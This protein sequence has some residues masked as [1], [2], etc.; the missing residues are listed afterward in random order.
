MNSSWYILRAIYVINMISISNGK[1]FRVI[2]TILHF[3][4]WLA[5]TGSR[6]KKTFL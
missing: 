5:V 1:D 6:I 2:R 4:D 3:T